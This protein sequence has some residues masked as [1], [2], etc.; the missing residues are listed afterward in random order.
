MAIVPV[1]LVDEY[2]SADDAQRGCWIP[3]V[4]FYQLQL[5]P[6]DYPV[7]TG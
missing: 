1:D 2:L 7:Q 6:L 4:T 5:P 3:T